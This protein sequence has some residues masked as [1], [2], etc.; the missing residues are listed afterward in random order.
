[1]GFASS[2]K[3]LHS[4]SEK[5]M[6][7]TMSTSSP[8]MRE[9]RLSM[10]VTHTMRLPTGAVRGSMSITSKSSAPLLFQLS[11]EIYCSGDQGA[12]PKIDSFRHVCHKHFKS[13][14]QANEFIADWIETYLEMMTCESRKQLQA[15][16]RPAVES[17]QLIVTGLDAPHDRDVSDIEQAMEQAHL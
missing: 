17:G 16:W 3:Q 6:Q 4:C 7:S 5:D 12:F 13:R 10:A 9:H 11:S 1:M 15:G 14:D 8:K 2:M